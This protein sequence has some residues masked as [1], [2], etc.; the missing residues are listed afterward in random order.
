M[1]PLQKPT[2]RYV[3]DTINKHPTGLCKT[4]ASTDDI[5]HFSH[6]LSKYNIQRKTLQKALNLTQSQMTLTQLLKH[7]QNYY[8]ILKFIHNC[9]VST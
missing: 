2:T 5:T 8:D 1:G 7:K 6:K 9:N 4:C 3:V